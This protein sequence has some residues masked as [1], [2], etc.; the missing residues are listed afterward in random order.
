[1]PGPI[2]LPHFTHITGSFTSVSTGQGIIVPV[3]D[4]VNYS[5]TGTFSGTAIIE[6][7]LNNLNWVQY[8]AALTAAASGTITND[9][10]GG[11][12]QFRFRC[13]TYASGTLVSELFRKAK[14]L[15]LPVGVH[16]KA[17]A[18]SGFV[19]GATDN[20]CLATC[21][22][23]KTAATLVVP[24][25]GLIV[26]EKITSFALVGQIESAGGTVTV[27]ASLHRHNAV[28]AD[29]TDTAVASMAQLS[30]TADTAIT[31]INASVGFNPEEVD[32]DGSYFL[33]ITVTTAASTDVALQA[34]HIFKS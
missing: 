18:T 1:M 5:L 4:S 23:S 9:G 22:A 24:V 32:I 27:D 6:Y 8:G 28:A 26:G 31:P 34:I 17:G 14:S 12:A 7:S 29:V 16:A 11:S 13:T 2:Q 20:I 10:I 30:V 3:G 25:T 19:I 15:V 21:P 33:L